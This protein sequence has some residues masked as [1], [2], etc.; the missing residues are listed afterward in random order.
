MVSTKGMK[1]YFSAPTSQGLLYNDGRSFSTYDNDRSG[2]DCVRKDRGGWWYSTCAYANLNG[3][4]AIPGSSNGYKN[5]GEAGMTYRSFK[6]EESLK[7]SK[8]MLR[9]K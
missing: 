7:S 5:R 8:M 6:G 2:Y 4:Y 3:Y 1:F 9:R